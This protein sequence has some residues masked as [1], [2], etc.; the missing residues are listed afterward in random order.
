VRV[1][2]GVGCIDAEYF[3][4]GVQGIVV[5]C[6]EPPAPA[7][8]S[9]HFRSLKWGGLRGVEK[10]LI[11]PKRSTPK[12]MRRAA[13]LRQQQTEPEAILWDYLRSHRMD[14]ISFRRQHAIGNYIV[15]FCAPRR[16][17]IIELDGSQHLHQQE[18]DKDRS[19]FFLQR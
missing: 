19:A 10:T 18:Y 13:M 17:L 4:E 9:P 11:P 12:M 2:V 6:L 15:D 1:G 16:K 3:G 14:G 7:F 5:K 8:A